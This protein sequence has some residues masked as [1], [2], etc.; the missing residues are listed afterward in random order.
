MSMRNRKP[1]VLSVAG[2][3]ALGAAATACSMSG[4]NLSY[5]PPA[6]GANGY[7]YYVNSP[8]EV[9]YLWNSG[10]CPRAWHPML[11]PMAWYAMYAPYYDSVGYYGRFPSRYQHSYV[12]VV[13]RW[14]GQHKSAISSYGKKATWKGTDGKRYSGNNVQKQLKSGKG[15]FGSGNM[16]SKGFSSQ[17]TSPKSGGGF[18][19][20][21]NKGSGFGSGSRSGGSKSSGWGS[22]SKSGSG[23]SSGS[24]GGFSS[25]RR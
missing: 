19:G 1:F 12:T 9:N 3:V 22:G 13:H 10:L 7:C 2:A 25:G 14:E 6:Y 20:S 17:K 24:R 15:S 5:V 8:L 4:D 23:F 11:M 21:T 18:W 16:R